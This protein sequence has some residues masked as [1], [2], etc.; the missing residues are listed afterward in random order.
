[1]TS[2]GYPQPG[3]QLVYCCLKGDVKDNL[4][5]QLCKSTGNSPGGGVSPLT[6]GG[7]V[8]NYEFQLWY[9]N[10]CI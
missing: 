3:L 2:L 4:I 5:G 1:M 6:P 8:C 10:I 9:L 7:H